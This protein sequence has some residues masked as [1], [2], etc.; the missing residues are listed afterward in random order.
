MAE[1]L[2]YTGHTCPGCRCRGQTPALLRMTF[3]K[4][5]W[6]SRSK[7]RDFLFCDFG[8]ARYFLHYPV[9]SK[10]GIPSTLVSTRKMPPVSGY[11]TKVASSKPLRAEVR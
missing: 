9:N 7:K 4:V 1:I 8:I 2:R 10:V 5:K 3:E 11:S 6:K